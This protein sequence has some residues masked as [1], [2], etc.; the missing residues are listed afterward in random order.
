[1]LAKG[2]PGLLPPL[3]PAQALETSMIHSISGGRP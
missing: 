3:T 1:M 2:I